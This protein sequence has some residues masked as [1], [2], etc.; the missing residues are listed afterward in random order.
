MVSEAS[1]P[2]ADEMHREHN[3]IFYSLLSRKGLTSYLSRV[4]GPSQES[5]ALFLKGICSP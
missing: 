2:L 4:I 1:Q 3:S 5:C